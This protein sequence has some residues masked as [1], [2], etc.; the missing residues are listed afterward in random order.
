M[1]NKSNDKDNMSEKGNGINKDSNWYAY[2][3]QDRN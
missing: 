1:R 2:L 3:F